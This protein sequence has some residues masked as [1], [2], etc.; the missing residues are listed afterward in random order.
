MADFRNVDEHL[1]SG[2]FVLFDDSSD[3]GPFESTRTAQEAAAL[4][5]YELVF[6][7]PNYL[8]EKR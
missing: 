7:A 3:R 8:L 6:K 4:A 1:M 2:G 5:R